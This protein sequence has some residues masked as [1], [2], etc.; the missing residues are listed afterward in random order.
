MSNRQ[1][2]LKKLFDLTGIVCHEFVLLIRKN[3]LFDPLL[4]DKTLVS[5][6]NQTAA[7]RGF[8]DLRSTLYLDLVLATVTLISDKSDDTASLPPILELLEKK[9]VHDE[10]R[11][12]YVKPHVFNWETSFDSDE[13]RIEFE[14]LIHEREVKQL[15][16][17]FD[18]LYRD[19][20]ERW[21]KMCSNARVANLKRIRNKVLS[22]KATKTE[23]SALRAFRVED[24]GLRYDDCRKLIEAAQPIFE[25]I[26]SIVRKTSYSFPQAK[27]LFG[28]AAAKFWRTCRGG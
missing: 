9:F 2:E 25:N 28:Q 12:T 17:E 1:A 11:S 19:T 26:G 8:L 23:N 13:E 22:H 27:E 7:G 18:H 15:C 6:Y 20:L 24:I 10:L 21:E 3:E 14:R 4:K 5:S 16:S